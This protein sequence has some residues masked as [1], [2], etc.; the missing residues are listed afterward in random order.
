MLIFSKEYNNVNDG[1]PISINKNA[2][3][4]VQIISKIL[5]CVNFCDSSDQLRLNLSK[6]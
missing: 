5:A 4:I 2:G 3:I 6:T 1:K